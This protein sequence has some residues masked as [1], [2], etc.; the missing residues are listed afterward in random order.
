MKTLIKY[1]LIISI[2]IKCALIKCLYTGRNIGVQNKSCW[3]GC[4]ER[5]PDQERGKGFYGSYSEDLQTLLTPTSA[6]A[7]RGLE[8]FGA[9]C[10]VS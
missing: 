6:F 8:A 2:I 1:A 9:V 7:I 4:K 10:G 5:P 3:L